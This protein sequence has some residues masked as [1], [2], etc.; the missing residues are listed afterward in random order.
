MICSAVPLS[1]KAAAILEA[2]GSASSAVARQ[3]AV[4]I[5]LAAPAPDRAEAHEL[6]ASGYLAQMQPSFHLIPRGD[7][8]TSEGDFTGAY[9]TLVRATRGFTRTQADVLSGVLSD[10]PV[11]LAPLRMILG[12]THAEMAAAVRIINSEARTSSQ[13][14]RKFERADPPARLT[15]SRRQLIADLASAA[16]A[17]MER[18]ILS[19]PDAVAQ[20]FHS[21]LDK[22]D[23][24]DGW[25]SVAASVTGVP[26]SALLYQRYVG[27][28]WRQVQ[29]AYSETKGDAL[30]ERPLRELLLTRGIPH[31][32]TAAG[33]SGAALTKA[34][35]EIS[36]APD[37][38]IPDSMP[39]VAIE[40]KVG[41][42]GG[43]VRDKAA[44]IQEMA[45]SAN[46]VGLRPCAL[47]DGRGWFERQSALVTVILATQGRTYS[48]ATMEQLLELPELAELGESE[49]RPVR[50]RARSSQPLR[51]VD[52][53]DPGA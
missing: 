26:Y 9:E 25:R 1:K 31:H 10:V 43:T 40:A 50:G 21:K 42:D 36:P 23:T 13:T 16:T 17:I 8:M 11:T 51:R 48:L 39:T 5:A 49:P 30:L 4:A 7:S 15:D 3:Q 24:I 37:F 44:R 32:H 34:R 28:V 19:V 27:G 45:N 29:D 20:Y 53:E 12:F 14:L 2:A 46:A 47:I 6:L 33:A 22:R 38:L 52:A 41:E 18:R 35:Y